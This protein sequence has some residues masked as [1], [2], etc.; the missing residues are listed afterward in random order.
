MILLLISNIS[1]A[2]TETSSFRTSAGQQVV[3][4]DS[5]NQLISKTGQSP[6]AIKSTIWTHSDQKL[7]AMTYNYEIGQ[8]IYS[9]T[10][11]QEQVLKIEWHQNPI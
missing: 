3:I 6:L 2:T 1:F 9:V 5:L 8:M 11:V 4:G 10:V 7:N